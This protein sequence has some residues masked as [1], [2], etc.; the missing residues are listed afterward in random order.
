M[1]KKELG[2]DLIWTAV[3]T[4]LGFLVWYYF[5]RYILDFQGTDSMIYGNVAMN[6]VKK[7]SMESNFIWAALSTWQR[8]GSIPLTFNW[9]SSPLYVFAVALFFRVFGSSFW[10]MKLV[11]V[12]FGALSVIPVYF[13]A[14]K[15]L[16]RETAI[17]ASLIY[18]MFPFLIAMA[19]VPG[20]KIFDSFMVLLTLM[21]VCLGPKARYALVSGIVCGLLFL[22]RYDFGG[23]VFLCSLL[24][25]SVATWRKHE[26]FKRRLLVSGIFVLAVLGP[27][28]PW[29]WRTYNESGYIFALTGAVA[30][31]FVGRSPF[32]ISPF[33]FAVAVVLLLAL[34]PL[35]GTLAG[36]VLKA[37]RRFLSLDRRFLTAVV[38]IVGVALFLVFFFQRIF[39]IY[40]VAVLAD[41]PQLIYDMSPFVFILA[42]VGILRNVRKIGILHPVYTFPLFMIVVYTIIIVGSGGA[43]ES[44][45]IV[46]YLSL[47]LIFAAS[48]LVDI[49]HLFS[50][51][52]VFAGGSRFFSKDFKLG[53][54]WT[55]KHLMLILLLG[56]VFLSLLPQ[57]FIITDAANVQSGPFRI[58]HFNDVAA[59][60]SANT[61]KTDT[62]MARYPYVTFYTGRR[63]I[64]LEPMNNTQ[65]LAMIR[66]AR[67]SY[68]VVDQDAYSESLQ[69]PNSVITYLWNFPTYNLWNFTVVFRE[70]NPTV[71]IFDVRNY[72][73]TSPQEIGWL[74]DNFT[75][76]WVVDDP[77][78]TFASNGTAAEMSYNNTGDRVWLHAWKTFDHPVNFSD[79]PFMII[80]YEWKSW[81]KAA[82]PPL[83][84]TPAGYF[85][86][87]WYNSTGGEF[88]SDQAPYPIG[89][90]Y[91]FHTWVW[92]P[93]KGSNM[94]KLGLELVVGGGTELSIVIDY[95]V[96]TSRPFYI[97]G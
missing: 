23:G 97:K 26:T 65:L 31:V 96:I 70:D 36:L 37:G 19:I 63:T 15:V 18:L 64:V 92:S 60:I 67:I 38:G 87:L 21:L 59:W 91:G 93:Q 56:S 66:V 90:D 76:G 43:I 62:I 57:Y 11:G 85:R 30:N 58:A 34:S 10:T 81:T 84:E 89:E 75:S 22:A 68:I 9:S 61:D 6:L 71:M 77:R 88:S 54:A 45:Y 24:F 79:Y 7:G 32:F 3:T 28:V 80:G 27:V 48:S 72:L 52:P 20:D 55:S 17:V 49:A 40:T 25:Y 41:Y 78:L 50:S 95:I 12:V 14:K 46:P 5:S 39:L 94:A 73:P 33:I 4:V 16:G 82:Y 44:P 86:I 13:I 29:L 1:E 74:D 53:V 42:G 2:K 8:S 47:F 51:V 35:I 83:S 69:V